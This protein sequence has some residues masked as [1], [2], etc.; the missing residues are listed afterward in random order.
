MISLSE[1]I[2]SVNSNVKDFMWIAALE[3]IFPPLLVFKKMF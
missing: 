1:Q 3:Y 2:S